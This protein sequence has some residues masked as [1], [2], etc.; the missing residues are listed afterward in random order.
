MYELVENY[1][2]SCSTCQKIYLA[3]PRLSCAVQC[4]HNLTPGPRTS[5]TN[6]IGCHLP[7]YRKSPTGCFSILSSRDCE[8]FNN[9]PL[10]HYQNCIDIPTK[11]LEPNASITSDLIF[12]IVGWKRFVRTTLPGVRGAPNMDH[13]NLPVRDK[14][15]L[16]SRGKFMDWI[17]NPGA[18]KLTPFQQLTIDTDW[19]NSPLGPISGWPMQL[20]ST[21]LLVCADPQPVSRYNSKSVLTS[22]DSLIIGRH[23]NHDSI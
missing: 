1:N 20:R 23:A 21:V 14:S 13:S 7:H 8:I 12:M 16:K 4:L 22:C 10:Y 3:R 6:L 15:S 5:P 17:S 18:F 9:T 2:L 11:S 19:E